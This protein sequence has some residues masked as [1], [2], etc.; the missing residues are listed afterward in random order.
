MESRFQSRLFRPRKSVGCA[1]RKKRVPCG[2]QKVGGEGGCT[3]IIYLSAG[4]ECPHCGMA[5]LAENSPGVVTCPICGYGTNRP[6][7]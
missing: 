4:S 1:K 7:T 6:V 3:D 2:C 5:A